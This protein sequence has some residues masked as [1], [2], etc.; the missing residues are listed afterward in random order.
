MGTYDEE[1]LPPDLDHRMKSTYLMS[2][3][4]LYSVG[5][6]PIFLRDVK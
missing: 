4:F 5:F 1:E 3:T 2:S 6:D